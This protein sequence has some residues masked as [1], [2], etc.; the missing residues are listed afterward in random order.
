MITLKAPPSGFRQLTSPYNLIR[1]A[2][3]LASVIASMLRGRVDFVLVE[4]GPDRVS[5]WRN[6][7]VEL[8]NEMLTLTKIR[9]GAGK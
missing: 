4:E 6:N 9:G 3:M 5:V 8:P 7:W 2:E 1:E